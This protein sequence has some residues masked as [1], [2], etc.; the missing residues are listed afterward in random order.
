M[1]ASA[2]S[3]SWRGGS[4]GSW[5]SLAGLAASD[6][7]LQK[8]LLSRCSVCVCV[9]LSLCGRASVC[10]ELFLWEQVLSLEVKAIIPAWTVKCKRQEIFWQTSYFMTCSAVMLSLSLSLSRSVLSVGARVDCSRPNLSCQ[11]C[12]ESTPRLRWRL[13][14]LATQEGSVCSP[15]YRCTQQELWFWEMSLV[16]LAHTYTHAHTCM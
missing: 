6:N 16:R 1:F 7:Y 4:S 10:A 13:V 9:C 2:I 12:W 14:A 15:K 8:L 3:L 5:P 11:L